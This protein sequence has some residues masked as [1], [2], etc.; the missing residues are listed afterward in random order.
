[1]TPVEAL[2]LALSKENNAIKVYA[3][4]SSRFPEIQDLLSFLLNEEQKHKKM[5]E[6][7]IA[8]M[9]K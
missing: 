4:L 6:G 9:M 3:D 8:E 1:M 5:I 7:K 2:N